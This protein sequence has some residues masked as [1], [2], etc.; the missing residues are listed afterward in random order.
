MYTHSYKIH[1]T[2]DFYYYRTAITKS[3][4]ASPEPNESGLLYFAV[5]IC[6]ACGQDA[7]CVLQ[8][9]CRLRLRAKSVS[10]ASSLLSI[11]YHQQLFDYCFCFER[12]SSKSWTYELHS[13]AIRLFITCSSTDFRCACAHV[14]SARPFVIQT[15]RTSNASDDPM[16]AN[17]HHPY[18]LIQENN[19]TMQ[20]WT[21]FRLLLWKNWLIQRRH[22]LQSCLE[23]IVPV[24]CTA[25][26][27]LLRSLVRIVE[28]PDE[29]HYP[30]VSI[31]T[32]Q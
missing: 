24:L 2:C 17:T 31:N 23:I 18:Q 7:S 15:N 3:H 29:W 20:L 10:F 26:L 30:A 6:R 19:T 13:Y 21:K 4:I 14:K 9:A 11:R 1:I 16:H 8:F 27:V 28:Y 32:L 22:P 25:V 5:F 12:F